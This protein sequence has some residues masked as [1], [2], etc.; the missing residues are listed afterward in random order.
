MA[1]LTHNQLNDIINALWPHAED[2][3]VSKKEIALLVGVVSVSNDPIDTQNVIEDIFDE[4]D[5][6]SVAPENFLPV[7]GYAYT[8]DKDITANKVV[9]AIEKSKLLL[10]RV[11]TNLSSASLDQLYALMGILL[12]EKQGMLNVSEVDIHTN[13]R[14]I[15]DS[16]NEM[17]TKEEVSEFLAEYARHIECLISN[18]ERSL[19]LPLTKEIVDALGKAVAVAIE[20]FEIQL[21][22]Y[23]K[24]FDPKKDNPI[25]HEEYHRII[26]RMDAAYNIAKEKFN[27]STK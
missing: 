9:A 15:V 7:L 16:S 2:E 14:Q 4:E 6:A 23:I 20:D 27:Y 5:I 21:N 19:R 13:C 26:K 18:L 1:K 24:D 11:V 3:V 22:G 17:P 12:L 10:L 8:L 25:M